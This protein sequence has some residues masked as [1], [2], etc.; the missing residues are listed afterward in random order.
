MFEEAVGTAMIWSWP[1]RLP[2]QTTRPESVSAC[3]FL[4]GICELTGVPAP[5]RNLSGRSYLPLAMGKALTKKQAWRNV[6]FS[7]LEN[8]DMVRDSRNKLV[9]RDGG[10]GANE[11]YDLQEDPREENNGYD[12]GR[13]ASIRPDLTTEIAKWRQKYSS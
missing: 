5:N 8:A 11:F 2:P 3:D 13:Y 10:K 12:D 7:H 9:L 1:K 6:V 4:P